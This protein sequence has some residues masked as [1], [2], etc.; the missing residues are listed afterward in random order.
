MQALGNAANLN[1]IYASLVACGI[2]LAGICAVKSRSDWAER[3]SAY[4]ISFAAGVI[5]SVSL[6][7]LIPKSMSMNAEAPYYVLAGFMG[8]YL[9]NRSLRIFMCHDRS[10]RLLS[11]GVVSMIAIGL[12]SFIDGIIYSVTFRASVLTGAL[13]TAGMILH[14]FPE[15]IVTYLVLEK[16]GFGRRRS[17]ALA[18]ATAALTTPLGAVAAYPMIGRIGEAQLGAVLGLS[19]GCLIY[20]GATHLLPSVEKESGAMTMLSLLAGIIAAILIMFLGD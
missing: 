6:A 4:F 7:H 2:T 3:N 15:G 14:E 19:A 9:V 1:S 12:H 5:V 20:L 13:A 8:L 17:T 16:S 11:L 10:R 18:F